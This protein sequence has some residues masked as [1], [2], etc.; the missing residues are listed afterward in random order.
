MSFPGVIGAQSQYARPSQPNRA[1]GG[2]KLPR[3]SRYHCKST[4]SNRGHDRGPH[5]C[6]R[7]TSVTSP[8]RLPRQHVIEII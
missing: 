5:R 7:G 8:S 6:E 3:S 2:G 4:T 1:T